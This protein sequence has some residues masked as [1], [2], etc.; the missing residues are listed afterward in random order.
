MLYINYF[1]IEQDQ[2]V[3]VS[4]GNSKEKH[5]GE[6]PQEDN[7]NSDDGDEAE[8][9]DVDNEDK[10]DENYSAKDAGYRKDTEKKS[11]PTSNEM[12]ADKDVDE[13]EMGEAQNS[14]DEN[15][16]DEPENSANNPSK[17]I[18][19]KSGIIKL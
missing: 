2:V 17:T 1:L 7:D 14:L 3:D 15:E 16:S 9:S 4:T 13:N 10:H 12:V 8:S 6:N 18:S 19:K 5:H 11:N